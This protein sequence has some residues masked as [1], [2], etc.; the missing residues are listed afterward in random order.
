MRGNGHLNFGGLIFF[1][2]P[3]DKFILLSR[4]LFYPQPVNVWADKLSTHLTRIAQWWESGQGKRKSCNRCISACASGHIPTQFCQQEQNWALVLI[5]ETQLRGN[6]RSL[7]VC[8]SLVVFI[9][10]CIFSDKGFQKSEFIHLSCST[11][12]GSGLGAWCKLKR[13][14]LP[15]VLLEIRN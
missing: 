7:V 6:R 14:V 3:A 10:A 11:S 13:D 5:L 1:L 15:T 8:T 2:F 12:L 9:L 4:S